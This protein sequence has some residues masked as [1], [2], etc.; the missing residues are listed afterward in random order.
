MP[1]GEANID[2]GLSAL[3][4]VVLTGI[5]D[6]RATLYGDDTPRPQFG[7]THPD[8]DDTEIALTNALLRYGEIPVLSR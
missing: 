1:H 3:D 2:R 6:I 4:G 5:A 7:S 8:R